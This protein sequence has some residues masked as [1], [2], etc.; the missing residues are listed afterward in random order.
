MRTRASTRRAFASLIIFRSY[1]AARVAQSSKV[2]S[3]FTDFVALPL[4]AV[5]LAVHNTAYR[6]RRM[7]P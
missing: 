5:A 2:S 1:S 3:A 6:D 7:G 4:S